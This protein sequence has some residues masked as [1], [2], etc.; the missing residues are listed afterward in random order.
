M[1]KG[2]FFRLGILLVFAG[3]LIFF[4]FC[5]GPVPRPSPAEPGRAQASAPPLPGVNPQVRAEQARAHAASQALP[6]L[7]KTA[8]AA[9]E[10]PD[11][12][13]VAEVYM[14]LSFRL[15]LLGRIPEADDAFYAATAR[16]SRI[17]DL[18]A[19]YH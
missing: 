18:N 9:G 10:C 14:G 5:H 19:P 12:E 4:F 2:L 6:W 7:T 15:A 3:G 16:I 8:A 11:P 1:D 17:P 13:A